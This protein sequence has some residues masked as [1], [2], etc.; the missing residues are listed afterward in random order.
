MTKKLIRELQD[1]AAS[2]YDTITLGGREI[3][4]LL[5]MLDTEWC[6]EVEKGDDLA[7]AVRSFKAGAKERWGSRNVRL[8]RSV[9]DGREHLN[10][11]VSKVWPDEGVVQKLFK[12]SGLSR[13]FRC[14]GVGY[15]LLP[16][17]RDIFF[18][19][20]KTRSRSRK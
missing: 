14:V 20:K 8:V 18:E 1:T 4:L 6:P 9:V 7:S 17:T 16:E 3:R 13:Y 15:D 2:E 5:A 19:A 12:A 10:L 11:Q